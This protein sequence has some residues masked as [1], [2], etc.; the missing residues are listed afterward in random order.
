MAHSVAI[1]VTFVVYLIVLLLI[2][3]WGDRKFSRSYRDF[4]TAGKSL[5]AWVTAISAS[6]SSESAWVMLG[7]SGMG[8]TKG[9]AAYWAAFAC[10]IGYFVNALWVMAKLRKMSGQ[11]D[12]YTVSDF[13]E[14][15]LFDRGHTL[16]IISAIIIS[17]FMLSYVIAQFVGSGKTIS[18]MGITS[19]T[20]G[21][22]IGGIIITAYVLLGGYAAVA[23]TDLLQ[24]L[25]MAAVMITFPVLAVIEAG[26]IGNL[27][28]TL[29]SLNLLSLN[30]STGLTMAGVGF[31]LGT[32]GISLGYPGMPH[33]IVRFITVRDIKE[34]KRAAFISITW[35]ILVL[36]GS[37]TLGIAARVLFPGLEDA[38]R[39]LP[40]FTVTYLPPVLAGI[41]LSAI[42]A[43]IMSTADS[44]L[45]YAS[46]A[47]VNDLWLKLKKN[48]SI[49]ERKLV[50]STRIVIGIMALLA[51]LIALY[52]EKYIYGFVLY[53]WS[54][55]GA[56]F[57]PIILLSL[58][59]KRYTRWGALASLIS[60]PLVTVIWH[61][62]PLL[63]KA[64]YELVPAFLVSLILSVVVSLL[65]K[66]PDEI[67]ELMD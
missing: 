9:L 50:R 40:T 46:T 60:G 41:V 24:G 45:M 8:Y 52:E 37:V 63:S 4:V 66:A 36:F 58:Y 51:L 11:F 14:S 28:R 29:H 15:R 67:M 19:Y 49:S 54:A 47:V 44:Q 10:I 57:T 42:T 25:L 26:G 61:N 13:I 39:A 35:A 7:L 17:V 34:A 22:L 56:A 16:R 30:G 5:G 59:W 12:S 33:V 48:V 21:V 2:G 20:N 1:M 31:I 38:E 27:T 65:T 62:V 32:L 55:L 18:G 6:A 64:I 23:F 53:A 43:A 3:Y